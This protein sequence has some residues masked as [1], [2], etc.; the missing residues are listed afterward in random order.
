MLNS[1]VC[2][3]ARLA[4]GTKVLIARGGEGVGTPL[5]RFEWRADS[6]RKLPS[7]AV[8]LKGK[9][10]QSREG[11]EAKQRAEETLP[12]NHGRGGWAKAERRGGR[13]W[14]SGGAVGSES[15]CAV[16]TA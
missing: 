4:A 12:K 6:Q 9:R 8:P 13:E 3:E 11:A 16:G 5:E 14:R 1:V 10:R 15:R 7:R 2:S